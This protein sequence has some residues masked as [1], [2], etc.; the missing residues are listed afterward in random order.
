M[1][2][3]QLEAPLGTA[4]MIIMITGA[5]GA[6]GGMIRMSGVGD[7]MASLANSMSLSYVLLA[8]GVTA[9]IRIARSALMMI[10]GVG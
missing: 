4:G 2:A 6:F 9:F 7:S 10:T 8:W 5:G 1:I 3:K